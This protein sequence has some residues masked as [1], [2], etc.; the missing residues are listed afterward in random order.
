MKAVKI[1]LIG[2]A[3]ALLVVGMTVTSY[4]FH[5]GG[6]AECSGCHSMHSSG[7]PDP[8]TGRGTATSSVFLLKG[9]DQS[10]ACLTCHDGPTLS[11]YHVSST[12]VGAGVAPA[13]R[14]PGGDFTWLLKTY[15]WT[16][17][18]TPPPVE[19]EE[20]HTHGHN[21]LAADYGYEVQ[22]GST[23]APGGTVFSSSQLGCQSC[24]D[25]HSSIRRLPDGTYMKPSVTAGSTYN[26]IT[27]AGSYGAT[28]PTGGAVGVYRL[29]RSF[30]DFSQGPT[31][32]ALFVAVAPSTYNQAEATATS[33]VRV[34][35]G[36]DG[37]DHTVSKWCATCHP[38][39][40]TSSGKL[41]HPVDRTL[42]DITANYNAYVKT[43]DLT[44]TSA[45]SFTSLVPFAESTANI[46]TLALHAKNDGSYMSGPATSDTVTCL[47]C[48][49]AH[50][51]GWEYAMR[52]NPE[53]EFLTTNTGAYPSSGFASRGHSQA[54]VQAAY[55]DRP[56]TV[57]GIS[58]RSL[59]N[60]CH[61]KD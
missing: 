14:T 21:I 40:H 61:V 4:A 6:V 2:L 25:P 18:G 33:Q 39:M 8:A 12:A 11:S 38:D 17:R 19:T 35:Y 24:H 45:N 34:A 7:K 16:G 52:W 50:A 10:S 9:T 60:K 23:H 42:G 56:N 58:Q 53:Y 54:E 5:S 57:F 48:H 3:I 43:G 27:G 32:N 29:L 51:S 1:T 44:G 37:T 28:P 15:T 26:P 49:R 47:S 46:A 36:A 55:Y 20:G 41:V 30:G 31:F 22:A 13:N 59:C